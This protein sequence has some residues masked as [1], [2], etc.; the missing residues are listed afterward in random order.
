VDRRVHPDKPQTS[1]GGKKKKKKNPGGPAI[2]SKKWLRRRPRTGMQ[3][4][5]TKISKKK[6]R[7]TGKRGAVLID[8]THRR[9]EDRQGRR[10]AEVVTVRGSD[11]G[12][13]NSDNELN[14]TPQR[15]IIHRKKGKGGKKQSRP[16]HRA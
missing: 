6:G 12:G 11:G 3:K 15:N 16:G 13:V 4:Q 9:A 14:P 2:A 1:E 8:R 10:S 7:E 5:K